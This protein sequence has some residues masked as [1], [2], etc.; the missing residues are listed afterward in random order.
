MPREIKIEIGPDGQAAI[1]A[2]GFKGPD[3]EK[4]TKAFE[5]ALGKVKTRKR[6]PEYTQT[7][8]NAHKQRA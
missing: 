6:K 1:E 5:E 2:V 3:C 7:A 4:F 8:V